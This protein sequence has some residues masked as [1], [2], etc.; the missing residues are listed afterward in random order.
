LEARRWYGCQAP[1]GLV[2]GTP[3]F[4]D[5]SLPL[6]ARRHG[7]LVDTVL[8]PMLVRGADELTTMIVF[9][10]V[11]GGL[12]AFGCSASS[13]GPVSAGESPLPSWR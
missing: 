10:G 5:L 8:R 2:D 7:L 1:S 11:F 6:G 12:A 3:R 13:S 9:I 4:R